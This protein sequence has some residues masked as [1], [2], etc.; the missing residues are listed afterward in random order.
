[1]LSHKQYEAHGRNI[2]EL[3]RPVPDFSYFG[4]IIG[5]P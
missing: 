1:M 4:E 5:C 2:R 3:N